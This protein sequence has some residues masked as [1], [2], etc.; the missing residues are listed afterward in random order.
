MG[1]FRQPG[2]PCGKEKRGITQEAGQGGSKT[3][4]TDSMFDYLREQDSPL[5]R[6]ARW[7]L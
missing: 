1:V 7:Q 6:K 5:W 3:K 2:D 4:V